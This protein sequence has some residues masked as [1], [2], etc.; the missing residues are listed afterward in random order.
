MKASQLKI[1]DIIRMLDWTHF[2]VIK[3][4]ERY[5]D[6]NGMKILVQKRDNPEIRIHIYPK[7]DDEITLIARF[8]KETLVST[9]IDK[10]KKYPIGMIINGEI[11]VE[12]HGP[13]DEGYEPYLT[14]RIER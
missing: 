11:I 2:K 8:G 3:F 13:D 14:I 7:I 12:E 9:L 1:G 6:T 5:H 10:L 4:E